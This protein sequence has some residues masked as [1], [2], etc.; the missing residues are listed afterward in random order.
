MKINK[1]QARH[2]FQRFKR[3]LLDRKWQKG[4][5][6]QNWKI[7]VNY[8]QLG[9]WKSAGHL[10]INW[11]A[12]K[13][14]TTYAKQGMQ[15]CC[16]WAQVGFNL[17][18]P[19]ST[20]GINVHQ[21]LICYHSH[22]GRF[23]SILL[24]EVFWQSSPLN[25]VDS[26]VIKPCCIAGNNNMMRLLRHVCFFVIFFNACCFFSSLLLLILKVINYILLSLLNVFIC[27]YDLS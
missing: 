3:F 13:L 9:A 7:C 6:C 16:V 14:Y 1:V 27:T 22:F 5:L 8:W 21:W 2:W 23:W 17:A 25:G 11:A 12:S 4:S 24:I 10:D 18:F 15:V 20:L 19:V 26:V